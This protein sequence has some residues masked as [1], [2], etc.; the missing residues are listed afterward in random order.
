VKAT[1]GSD[2]YT[3]GVSE[4]SEITA[5]S[6]SCT[7][8]SITAKKRGDGSILALPS[9]AE[10]TRVWFDIGTTI[11]SREEEGMVRYWHYHQQQRRRGD[12]SILA[13]PSTAE[14]KRGWFDTGDGYNHRVGRVLSFFSSRPNCDFPTPSPAGECI[15]SPFGFGGGVTHS[16]EG[17]GV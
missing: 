10:K 13:L 15:P 5:Y 11:N 8:S 12:G 1:F 9:T 4:L 16:I 2:W 17:E 14:K 6:G 3:V 7:K